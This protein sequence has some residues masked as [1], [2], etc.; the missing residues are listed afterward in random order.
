MATKSVSNPPTISHAAMAA[1]LARLEARFTAIDPYAKGNGKGKGKPAEKGSGKASGKGWGKAKGWAANT[2][3]IYYYNN[4]DQN[5]KAYKG[6]A[7]A[8]GSKGQG[9]WGKSKGKGKASWYDNAYVPPHDESSPVIWTCPYCNTKHNSRT[10]GVCRNR[11]CRM[12]R[13]EDDSDAYGP[14]A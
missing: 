11:N 9:A 1:Q 5:Y 12:P 7:G 6:K 10:C 4:N 8:K 2:S 14:E 13:V 3:Y